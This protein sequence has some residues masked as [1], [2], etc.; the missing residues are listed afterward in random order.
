MLNDYSKED[1]DYHEDWLERSGAYIDSGDMVIPVDSSN[2]S[3]KLIKMASRTFD[4]FI[5]GKV[6]DEL[7]RKYKEKGV[8]DHFNTSLRCLK[9]ALAGNL[10][11]DLT[12]VTLRPS[13][14]YFF[15]YLSGISTQDLEKAIHKNKPPFT[16]ETVKFIKAMGDKEDGV[17]KRRARKNRQS[18]GEF[19]RGIYMARASVLVLRLDLGYRHNGYTPFGKQEVLQADRENIDLISQHRDQFIKHLRDLFSK[20]LLG[21]V[22]RLEYGNE[23]GYHLHLII[24]LDGNL[25]QQDVLLCKNLGEYWSN[26]IT[27]DKGVYYNCNARKSKYRHLAIGKTNY[28]FV[29]E[30]PCIDN[31]INYF[32][33]D[34]W[35]FQVKSGKGHRTLGRSAIPEQFEK[36]RGRKRTKGAPIEAKTVA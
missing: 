19:V 1:E 22:W 6:S 9:E 5:Y 13:L 14:L 11:P 8:A 31:I 25:H 4:Y 33:K 3:M 7:K 17:F 12:H 23:K 29:M 21:Y 10:L 2:R 34:D 36:P 27:N 15:E 32:V 28:A 35:L 20:G 30:Q 18:I 24:M 16:L 26:K